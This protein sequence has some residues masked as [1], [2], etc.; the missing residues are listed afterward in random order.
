MPLSRVQASLRLHGR[1]VSTAINDLHPLGLYEYE[2]S[3]WISSLPVF[4]YGNGRQPAVC[5]IVFDENHQRNILP[6]E[7]FRDC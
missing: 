2:V 1:F 5:A 3:H 4:L 6:T 7:N